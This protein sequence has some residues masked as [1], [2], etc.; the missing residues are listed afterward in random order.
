MDQSKTFV[1][2]F[3]PV[4]T[5]HSGRQEFNRVD[6]FHSF[7]NGTSTQWSTYTKVVYPLHGTVMHFADTARVQ[8]ITYQAPSRDVGRFDMVKGD[9][10]VTTFNARHRCN[11]TVWT[12]KHFR[13]EDQPPSFGTR[14]ALRFNH[15]HMLHDAAL[16][17]ADDG[18]LSSL[19]YR[20]REIDIEAEGFSKTHPKNANWDF[21]NW[22]DMADVLARLNAVE[23]ILVEQERRGRDK[24]KKDRN[25]RKKMHLRAVRIAEPKEEDC[26]AQTADARAKD[27]APGDD[28]G[29]AMGVHGP[30]G[31]QSCEEPGPTIERTGASVKVDD[32]IS[33]PITLLPFEDAVVAADGMVYE[34][35]AITSWLETHDSS[36]LTGA[37]LPHRHIV[38]VPLLQQLVEML[39]RE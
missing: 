30:L 27:A 17:F 31:E 14:V 7:C 12:S 28:A 15:G 21:D 32:L 10:L 34:R 1:Y 36:P 39:K 5:G 26:G 9:E 18:T 6:H 24:A 19:T 38:A 11:G 20:G 37:P 2:R 3:G 4:V 13:L 35:S 8:K 16:A 29:G 22:H 25:R 23:L 33:C